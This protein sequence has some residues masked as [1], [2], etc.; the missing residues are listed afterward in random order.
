[1]VFVHQI[2]AYRAYSLFTDYIKIAEHFFP[3]FKYD[4]THV[5]KVQKKKHKY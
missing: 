2:Y 3:Y 4:N 5:H 1:M